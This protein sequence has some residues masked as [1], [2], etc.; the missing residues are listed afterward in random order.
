[1]ELL[2]AVKEDERT[3]R[4]AP[5]DSFAITGLLQ[6]YFGKPVRNIALSMVQAVNPNITLAD[7]EQA[8]TNLSRNEYAFWSYVYIAGTHEEANQIFENDFSDL[9]VFSAIRNLSALLEVRLKTLTGNQHQTFFPA[10]TSLYS[11]RTWWASF[12]TER[13]QVGATQNSV[14]PVDNQLRDA[15]NIVSI[16]AESN[17]W[18]SLL[19][20][21][22]TR[23]YTI[24]QMDITS[25]LIQLHSSVVLGHVINVMILADRY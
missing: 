18:K 20:A 10:I 9:Q 5:Q 6:E 25:P 19:V 24:H 2:K 15:I 4:I 11:T 21:Y 8:S 7:V 13:R 16:D 17:F 1:M 22:I 3:Y 23:N 12:E 14:I